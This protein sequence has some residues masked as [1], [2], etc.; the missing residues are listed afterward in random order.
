MHAYVLFAC[1]TIKDRH[2]CC[3]CMRV[4][5]S[6]HPHS[7][8]QHIK[9]QFGRANWIGPFSEL[10]S[11]WFGASIC[12]VS[13]VILEEVVVVVGG[14]GGGGGGAAAA[15]YKESDKHIAHIDTSYTYIVHAA[16]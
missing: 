3:V 15:A 8:C 13:V 2:L 16:I 9:F 10:I 14:G 12:V 6:I 1:L 11:S 5:V 7:M 4:C